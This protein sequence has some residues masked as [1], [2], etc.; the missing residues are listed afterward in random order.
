M[1]NDVGIRPKRNPVDYN[2]GWIPTVFNGRGKFVGMSFTYRG[3][4]A[5]T[6]LVN[7]FTRGGSRFY[8]FDVNGRDPENGDPALEDMVV[9]QKGEPDVQKR[10][11]QVWDIQ[12][13]LAE[14]AYYPQ[15]VPAWA[16][17]FNL[18]WPVMRNQYVWFGGGRLEFDWLDMSRPPAG[19]S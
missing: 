17:G 6:G 5:V 2:S 3:D 9:K 7:L 4:P 14:K 13:Y 16:T 12:R 10:R 11:A 8:G 1:F 15:F 18:A 19:K